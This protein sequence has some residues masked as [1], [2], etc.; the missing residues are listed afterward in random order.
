MKLVFGQPSPAEVKIVRWN[1]MPCLLARFET[2]TP[3]MIWQLDLAKLADL[4]ISVTEKEGSWLLGYTT[5]REAAFTTIASFDERHEAEQAYD[6]IYKTM[7]RGSASSRLRGPAHP[8]RWIFIILIIALI[9]WA[10]MGSSATNG[11]KNVAATSLGKVTGQ[12]MTEP[13]TIR[14]G[15]PLAA[16]DVL[17]KME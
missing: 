4:S 10:L 17:P 15:V 7:R 3:P 12:I 11:E 16:D 14:E 1:E 9:L 6:M 13:Q 5:P 2:S 8:I